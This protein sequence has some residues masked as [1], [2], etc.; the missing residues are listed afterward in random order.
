MNHY[1]GH[2]LSI[3]YFIHNIEYKLWNTTYFYYNAMYLYFIYSIS[4]YLFVWYIIYKT[5]YLQISMLVIEMRN[6][7]L[8]PPS[9]CSTHSAGCG[10]RGPGR[11]RGAW[12]PARAGGRA[13]RGRPPADTHMCTVISDT[14]QYYCTIIVSCKLPTLSSQSMTSSYLTGLILRQVLDQ[15]WA[16]HTFRVTMKSPSETLE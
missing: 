3:Y 8:P 14:S 4:I 2:F 11:G 16:E 15:I 6:E 7:M 9:L 5:K 12:R 13:C 10:C 1:T